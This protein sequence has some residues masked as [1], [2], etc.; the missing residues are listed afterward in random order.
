MILLTLSF[1]SHA[2]LAHDHIRLSEKIKNRFNNDPCAMVAAESVAIQMM[3]GLED[4]SDLD[5]IYVSDFQVLKS[6]QMYEL[7]VSEVEGQ[8]PAHFKVQTHCEATARRVD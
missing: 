3:S 7:W 5:L 4:P 1:L 8:R 2:V 6:R